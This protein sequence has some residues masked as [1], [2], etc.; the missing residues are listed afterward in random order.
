VHQFD[1][2]TVRKPGGRLI[3]AGTDVQHVADAGL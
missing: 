2:W 1:R 3:N